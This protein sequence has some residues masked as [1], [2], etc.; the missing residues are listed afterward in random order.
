MSRSASILGL[1]LLLLSAPLAS[2]DRPFLDEE[3]YENKQVEEGAPW[4]EQRQGLP[5]YPR[6]EDLV[7]FDVDRPG[8]PFTYLLDA[9]NLSVGEDGVVRYTLVIRA[10]SGSWNVSHEGMRCDTRD[11]KVYA[12][13]ARGAFKPMKNA[14]WTR[15]NLN[16]PNRYHS[17]LREF[18]FCQPHQHTPYKAEEIV[19]R[20]NS[21]PRRQDEPGFL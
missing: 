3:S 2:R 1:C 16:D 7:E 9:R 15:M 5:P 4:Q 13:G 8:T 18:Y 20:L 21:A 11:L 6:E 19:R 10:R 12:Y 14:Q 17:D